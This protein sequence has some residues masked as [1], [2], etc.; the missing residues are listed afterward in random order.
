MKIIYT[1][2]ICISC[3]TTLFSQAGQTAS[4]GVATGINGSISFSVGQIDYITATSLNGTITQ[5]IQQPYELFIVTEV[6]EKN[7]ELDVSAYP[8]PIL[9]QLFIFIENEEIKNMSYTIN[10]VCGNLI[11]EEKI[12][13]QNTSVFMN[14]FVNGVYFIKIFKN[15]AI[16]KTFKLIKN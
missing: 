15:S 3:V 10:D 9:D 16:A 5:G 8:N 4:G 6:N 13:N 7:L 11:V 2:I 12:L 1:I 14:D